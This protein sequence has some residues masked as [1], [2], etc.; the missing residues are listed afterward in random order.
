MNRSTNRARIW[1]LIGAFGIMSSQII[2]QTPDAAKVVAAAD[3]VISAAAAK[4]AAAP[5]CAV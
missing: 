5:G 3:K 1:I 4:A 2:G